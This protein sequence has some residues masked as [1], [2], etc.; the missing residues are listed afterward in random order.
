MVPG[1]GAHDLRLV[2]DVAH[3]TAKIER[4]GGRMVCVHR[5]GATRAFG[6]ASADIPGTLRGIGQPVL[7]PGSMGSASFVLAGT[8]AAMQLS[9]GSCCH[10]AGRAL[11]RAAA[12]RVVRGG[13]LRRELAHRGIVVRCP[14]N[15]EI[16]EEAPIAYKDVEAVVI[17]VDA[18]GIARKVARLRPLG[19]I[20]G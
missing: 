3:N 20:K 1:P 15:T 13:E 11:S 2:Y 4:H 5:K 14:S 19:V 16:A 8:E 7:I 12:K 10:G 6:P 17:V 9:L 18:V